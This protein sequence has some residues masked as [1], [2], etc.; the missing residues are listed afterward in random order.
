MTRDKTQKRKFEF[1]VLS[2]KSLEQQEFLDPKHL[3][4]N[5]YLRATTFN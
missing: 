5:T 2:Q 3:G 1:G 4:A